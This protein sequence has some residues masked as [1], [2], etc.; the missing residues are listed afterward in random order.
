MNQPDMAS[1]ATTTTTITNT[2]KHEQFISDLVQFYRNRG[3]HKCSNHLYFSVN[4]KQFIARLNGKRINL[5]ELYSCV[6]EYGGSY[7]VNQLNLWEEIYCK[8]FKTGCIGA[9]FSV[10]LRQIYNRYLLQYEKLNSATFQSDQWNEDEDDDNLFTNNNSSSNSYVSASNI[11]NELNNVTDNCGQ[12]HNDTKLY[13]SLLSGLP[14][15]INFAFNVA[16]ILS[17]CNRFDWSNDYKFINVILESMKWY[18]CVCDQYE[19]DLTFGRSTN[20]QEIVDNELELFRNFIH[21]S[22]KKINQEDKE[23]KPISNGTIDLDSE[24]NDDDD[25]IQLETELPKLPIKKNE[26]VYT[27]RRCNCYR[28]LWFRTCQ[29]E[30]VLKL[31]FDDENEQD[32][33]IDPNRPYLYI[34]I[35]P[36]QL[37][38]QQQRIE[39]IAGIILNISVTYDS[40]AVNRVSMINLMKLL[41]LLLRSNNVSYI[42]LSLEIL[43]NISPSL[44]FESSKPEPE[45]FYCLLDS[46]LENV[47]HRAINS[48]N[49]HNTT[50]SF[51]ILAR[52]ISCLNNDANLFLEPH[53]ENVNLYERI[54]QL[55]TCQYDI[56][57]L[58]ALLEFCLTLSEVRPFLLVQ[59]DD[60]IFIKILINLLNCDA[61]SHFTVGA[62]KKVKIIDERPKTEAVQLQQT[63]TVQVQNNQIQLINAGNQVVKSV[64]TNPTIVNSSVATQNLL[65]NESFAINWLRT[66]YEDSAGSSFKVNDIY[67][68]YVKYCCRN[69]RKNV[70]AAQ[71][72]SF[73][74]KRCFP[75]CNLNFNQS[76]VEGL[77]LKSSLTVP[78]NQTVNQSNLNNNQ[79]ISQHP[80]LMSPILKAH[81]STPPK[82]NAISG[83]AIQEVTHS[84]TNTSTLIKSLLANKL[85]NNQQTLTIT[86]TPIV[87]T[88]TIKPIM[89]QVS[90][91]PL[92][93][94]STPT[95]ILSNDN[96]KQQQDMNGQKNVLFTS[97]GPATSFTLT[98]TIGSNFIVQNNGQIQLQQQQPGQQILVVRTILSQGGQQNP[99]RLI[100]PASMITTQQRLQSPIPQQMN[101][102]TVA[103]TNMVQTIQGKLPD[104]PSNNQQNQSTPMV[105]HTPTPIVNNINT[106][107]SQQNQKMFILTTTPTKSNSQPISEPIIANNVFVNNVQEPVKSQPII[108]TPILNGDMKVQSQIVTNNS[109]IKNAL[110]CTNSHEITK[111]LKTGLE[112]ND[113]LENNEVKKLP[114]VLSNN[115]QQENKN[116]NSL[117][118]ELVNCDNVAETKPA[119][120]NSVDANQVKSVVNNVSPV[121]V[122]AVTPTPNSI[123]PQPLKTNGPEAEFECQWDNC[124]KKFVRPSEVFVHVHS[125]HIMIESCSNIMNCLWGGPEGKGPGCLSKRPKLSLLTHL[126]DFHC[127]PNILKQELIRRKQLSTMG[128][129]TIILPQPPAH[130][131]YAQNA[132]MLAIRRHA[133]NYVENSI[134]ANPTVIHSPLTVS[135]RLTSALILRNLAERSNLIKKSLELFE[136]QL[137][138]VSIA[139]GRD[140][141]RTVAQCLAVMNEKK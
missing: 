7:R 13:C 94:N 117:Q 44:S 51:E 47:V 80:Q 46:L 60:K 69:S 26:I 14:N 81:L 34:D 96:N 97:G 24:N 25:D 61:S 85:R 122:K 48:N 29:D 82:N 35:P 54:T 75:S 66:T 17:N 119:A 52:Y 102:F 62:F 95:V 134:A 20:H 107:Q 104:F 57:L 140:E 123:V 87:T 116:S 124:H 23:D 126:Q 110:E 83:S 74:I 93:I 16:T 55:L 12:V 127:N 129:T 64:V 72:F 136:P 99:V 103:G 22:I 78:V 141:S 115:V 86:S 130:P 28:Q 114:I 18:C 15:E 19:E 121:N 68:E 21:L 56:A 4:P 42:N 112:N 70:I 106:S 89:T 53:F 120:I 139:E 43:S 118:T 67:A 135:I 108:Q 41:L 36:N 10:A 77:T 76:I 88:Q 11:A 37:K 45:L 100:L 5:C 133:T 33:D 132:A 71:S 30:N 91:Q 92:T 73:L 27:E 2:N 90:S 3:I 50:K 32:Q 63:N 40:T 9:N 65:D 59:N 39:L 31:V 111:R 1:T 58:L 98:P 138:E 8:L 79:V 109:M 105:S 84:T 49:L 125:D 38:K 113:S 6:L 101:G 137:C 131:G 128:S